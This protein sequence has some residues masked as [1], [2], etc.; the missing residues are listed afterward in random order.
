MSADQLFKEASQLNRR[1]LDQF[2]SKVISLRAQRI[3]Q[4]LP[5]RES[6]LL[7]RINRGL[8]V[9][10]HERF[11]ELVKKRDAETLTPQEHEELKRLTLEVE[12]IEAERIENLSELARLR[13]TTLSALMESLGL[14]AP[15]YA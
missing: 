5:G 9:S 3:A 2:V 4:N 1:E 6:E 7:G 12:R 10:L 11:A 15:G 14:G 8:P 13:G